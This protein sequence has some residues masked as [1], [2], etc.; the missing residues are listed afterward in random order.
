MRLSGIE[1]IAAERQ[2]QVEKEGWTAK[3]DD[4]H[5]KG[6]LLMAAIAYADCN[7]VQLI[8]GNKVV[9]QDQRFDRVIYRDPWPE[10]WDSDWDK[11]HKHDAI[12]RLTIAGA[13]IAAEIDRL[14]RSV[15]PEEAPETLT[16]KGTENGISSNQSIST[17]S[18]QR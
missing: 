7:E 4:S 17:E 11:R 16:T 3:H 9:I 13:L 5:D 8:Q 14:L 18:L 10:D 12:K 1:R 2:R 15:E 6:Q